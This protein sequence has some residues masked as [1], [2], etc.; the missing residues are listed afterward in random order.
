MLTMSRN[1]F[2]TTFANTLHIG[3]V[4]TA[5]D[6]YVVPAPGR[7]YFQAALGIGNCVSFKGLASPLLLVAGLNDKTAEPSMI[8]RI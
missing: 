1:G 8:K 7:P 3:I 5:Y 4:D 2:A 6:T